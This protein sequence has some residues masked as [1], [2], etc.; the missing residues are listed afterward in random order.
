VTAKAAAEPPSSPTT[1][2]TGRKRAKVR[3]V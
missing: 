3:R 1:S 2:T